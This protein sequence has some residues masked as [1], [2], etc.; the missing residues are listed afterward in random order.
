MSSERS[1][2]DVLWDNLR[3]PK[4]SDAELDRRLREVR[5]QLPVPVFWLFGKAQSGKTSLVRAMTGGSR[6]EIGSGFRPCTRFSRLYP[7]PNPEGCFLQFLDTRGLG[8]VDYDPADDVALL[9][10]QSHCL[11]VV[12]KAMDHA[13]QCVVDPLRRMVAA[14]PDWPLIVVQTSLHEGYPASRMHHAQPY[15]F[16]VEPWPPEVPHD[17][18]RS[19]LAQRELFAGMRA[20]FVPVDFTLPEDGLAPEHYGLDALWDAI[21]Y[22][23]PLGLRSMLRQ[24]PA[25]RQPLCDAYFETAHP[26]ILGYALAAG[27]AGGIPLPLVDIPLLIGIQA[28][29]FHAIASIYRQPFSAQRM[30]EVFGTLGVGFFAR[31]GGRELLKSVPGFG[32][33]VSALFAAASTYALGCTLCAYFS[34]VLDGDVPDADFLRQLYQEQYEDG[35]RRLGGY[36]DRRS[37]G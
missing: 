25:A 15:P 26:H 8:E 23:L 7:F 20:R 6:A 1:F 33:A 16:A 34:R 27:A 22:A 14:H 37:Q 19:L 11:M 28:K 12:V 30:A 5:G 2:L 9:E 4:V 18:A 32:S 24:A 35:R 13:Q 31:L 29:L 21:E 36:L 3:A 10:K 17:L